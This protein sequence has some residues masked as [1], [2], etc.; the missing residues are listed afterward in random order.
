M[1]KLIFVILVLMIGIGGCS[2][3]K[4]QYTGF[5]PPEGYPNT[6]RIGDVTIGAEAFAEKETARNAFGFDIKGA[7]LLPVQ[8]VMNNPGSD[9]F[10][11]VTSQTF[12]VDQTSR[13][14]QLI[15]NSVAVERVT[16]ATETGA[17]A[18]GAGKKAMLGAAG[19]AILGAAIGIVS[20][21]NVAEAAGKGAAIGGAGGAVLGGAQEASSKDTEY[22]ISDDLREKG[23]EG[24]TIPPSSLVNGFLFFPAEAENRNMI[25]YN[26][27]GCHYQTTFGG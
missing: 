17:I 25:G 19:G 13:Y 8:I 6:Q 4:T 27:E 9:S 1:K 23:I 11:V 12:L 14:W 10:E 15:P 24:K 21:H 7:G 16:E 18:K 26:H 22:R 20:G 2:T 5:R 3:Y